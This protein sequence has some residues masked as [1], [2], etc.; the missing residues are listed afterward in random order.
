MT[1]H[2]ALVLDR[3]LLTTAL[4]VVWGG[5]GFVA[6]AS[7]QARHRL[8]TASRMPLLASGVVA[9][10]AAMAAVPIQT[11]EIAAG[12]GSALQIDII[13]TVTLKTDV[14]IATSLQAATS[15]ALLAALW[16]ERAPLTAI[17]AGL[18]LTETAMHGHAAASFDPSGYLRMLVMAI[19]VLSAAAWVGALVPFVM[20]VQMTRHADH[21]RD[22]V[23]SM[24]QFSRFGHIAVALVLTT[25]AAN[26]LL[27]PARL[28]W[29]VSSPYQTALLAKIAAV[30]AMTSI[31]VVNRYLIVP[32]G[33][34]RPLTSARLLITGATLEIALG[35]I[36]FALVASFGLESP[37][38]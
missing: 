21:R 13:E 15:V 24:V 34:N 12:W 19:H 18:A 37:T 4:S 22:A 10:V 3:F 1:P 20:T 28:S 7:G 23:A 25:G 29:D 6:I 31:A 36:A 35:L 2:D 26:V 33:Q 9:A 8:E 11:A 17:L 5:S 38:A 27:I 16:T 14:G 32:L 30:A